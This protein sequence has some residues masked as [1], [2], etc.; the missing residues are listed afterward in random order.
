KGPLVQAL[1][2]MKT[3][4]ESGLPL[5]YTIRL[6]VGSDEESDNTDIATY[7]TDHKPPDLG[8]VL[9]SAF[10]VVVGEKAW[11][12]LTVTV[13][14]PYQVEERSQQ[15]SS[16]KDWQLLELDSG[17]AASIVPGNAVAKLQWVGDA[18]GFNRAVAGF[19]SNNSDYRCNV[20]VDDKIVTLTITGR[21]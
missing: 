15:K 9:D 14:H 3:L 10:P 2:T 4:K 13:D 1:L 18:D 21:S 19:K 5:T 17:I 7:L 16:G 12:S 6:I 8:L 11:N 20:K